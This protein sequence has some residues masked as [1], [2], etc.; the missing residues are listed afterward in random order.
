M[1][2]FWVYPCWFSEMLTPFFACLGEPRVKDGTY[3][4]KDSIQKTL[5]FVLI[6]VDGIGKCSTA[7]PENFHGG[8]F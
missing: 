8:S 5:E 6:W 3:T 2:S 7:I 4:V 1:A